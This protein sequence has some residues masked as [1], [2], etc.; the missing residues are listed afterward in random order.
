MEGKLN[1]FMDNATMYFSK[2]TN[3]ELYQYRN[4]LEYHDGQYIVTNPISEKNIKEMINNMDDTD[5]N[6]FKN[7]VKTHWNIDARRDSD[8]D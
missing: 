1:K 2:T 6:D 7:F 4:I 5:S 8:V 3:K